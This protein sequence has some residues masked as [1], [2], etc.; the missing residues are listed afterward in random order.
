MNDVFESLDGDDMK[1]IISI[2]DDDE[3]C[4]TI[5]EFCRAIIIYAI[6][7]NYESDFILKSL[8]IDEFGDIECD[9]KLIE[10]KV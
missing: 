1:N 7:K 6:K 2:F 5:G 4:P 9:I 10:D 8:R 3:K